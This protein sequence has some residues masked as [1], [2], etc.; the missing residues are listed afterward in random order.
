MTNNKEPASMNLTHRTLMALAIAAAFPF[1]AAQETQATSA[2]ADA[3]QPGQLEQVI[4]TA[5]R[6]AEN[7]KDVPMSI[8]TVKG[9][10]LDVLTSG[11][12]DIRFLSGRS[13]SVASN[14]TT[15]ARSRA[16]TSV[17]WA[18]PTST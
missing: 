5:Q 10:K 16:F 4:V 17:A 14:P 18:I 11:G 12:Q 1:A 7:I 8:A 15:A 9:E 13:P 6:R 3:T 2:A